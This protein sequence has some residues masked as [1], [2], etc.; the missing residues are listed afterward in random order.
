MLR[1]LLLVNL[2]RLVSN[3][4]PEVLP[5]Q[6]AFI[7]GSSPSRGAQSPR[8]WNAAFR[9]L[10]IDGEMFPLDVSS[11]KIP[12]LATLLEHDQRVIGVAIAA[13]YKSEF[14]RFFA[15][16]LSPA[17]QKAGSINLLCRRSD[18]NFIGNNTDGMAAVE[19]LLEVEPNLVESKILVLGC[20]ATGRAVIAS[21][22]DIV[23]IQRISVVYRN[24]QH[25]EWLDDVGVPSC[26]FFSVSSVLRD[27]SVV[28]NC[29]SVGWGRQTDE[30]PLNVNELGLLP[31]AS[32]VFDVVYQPD[33]SKLL[34]NARSLNLRTLSGSRMNRLQAVLAF[35]HSLPGVK[36]EMVMRSM[37]SIRA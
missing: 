11:D 31:K 9:D 13:P 20:G 5:S 15:G 17:A 6:C 30:S 19:S 28:I 37:Q 14:A 26:P 24:P 23:G 18:S 32:L 29:T 22:I 1:D 27:N 4:M 16:Q 12:R 33:P 21:L 25:K 34:V 7:V 35:C 2:E 10:Q 8:L 3:P 36:R